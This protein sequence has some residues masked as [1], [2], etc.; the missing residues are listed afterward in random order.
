[1]IY[2]KLVKNISKSGFIL[3]SERDLE[4]F[5]TKEEVNNLINTKQDK[6]NNSADIGF[7][8][9]AKTLYITSQWKDIIN[10]NKQDITNIKP[11]IETNTNN[12]NQINQSLT[13]YATIEFINGE[14]EKYLNKET[15]EQDKTNLTNSINK[16]SEDIIQLNDNQAELWN[17]LDTQYLTDKGLNDIPSKVIYNVPIGDRNRPYTNGTLLPYTIDHRRV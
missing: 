15:Y 9:T 4:N 14:L 3:N 8:E 1:M 7:N 11:Q 10:Q 13:L 17:Y 16:N 5:Y 12:I 6:I 2:K